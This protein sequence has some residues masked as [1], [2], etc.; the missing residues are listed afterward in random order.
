MT[1]HHLMKVS[2]EFAR[3]IKEYAAKNNMSML[4][5]SRVLP[6]VFNNKTVV[7]TIMRPKRG[8]SR[9]LMDGLDGL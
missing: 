8:R 3:F 4:D 5:A 9:T 2:P 1:D 6:S 7:V